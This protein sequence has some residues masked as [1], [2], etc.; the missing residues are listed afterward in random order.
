MWLGPLA[1]YLLSFVIAFSSRGRRVVAPAIRLVPVAVTLLWVPIGSVG[2]WP[3]VPLLIVAYLGFGIVATALHGY[4]ALDRPHAAR[5]TEFYFVLSLGGVLGG[6]FVGV[7]A[8]MAFQGIWEYPI[9]LVAALVAVAWSGQF[10][11]AGTAAIRSPMG[12]SGTGGPGRRRRGLDLSPFVTGARERLIPYGLMAAILLA[13]V[14][15]VGL[16]VEPVL[17]WLGVGAL[18]LLVGGQPRF[19]AI[20]T[21]LLLVLV[22]F[23]LPGP[24]LFQERSFFGVTRVVRAADVV[25]LLHGTTLHGIQSVDPALRDVPMGYYVREGPAG[26]VFAALRARLGTGVARWSG[27]VKAVGPSSAT[28]SSRPN[29]E[30]ETKAGPS[31]GILGL[32]DG[33]LAVYAQPGDNLTF[34]EIDSVVVRVAE[35]PTLFTFLSDAKAPAHVVLGDGRL[36]LAAVADASHDLL[37]FDAFSSDSPPAHLLTV[38][39]VRDAMRTVRPGG[40]LVFHVSN[41][42]YDLSPAIAGAAAQLGYASLGRTYTPSA[43]DATTYHASSSVWVALARSSNAMSYLA[44]HGWAPIAPAAP[45]TDDQPDLLRFLRILGG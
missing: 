40:M 39:A 20:S 31:I 21:G 15:P 44:A 3:I 23:V 36:S 5:L 10:G 1:I 28:G 16:A 33:G 34:Y 6:A 42:Y 26:D 22:T 19:L 24:A 27:A 14:A 4:L 30:I 18:V 2:A 12:R 45:L 17:R 7:V 11:S 37:V 41:R 25:E 38:E 9:L 35:D 13:T 43:D 32:G 29:G 8:P